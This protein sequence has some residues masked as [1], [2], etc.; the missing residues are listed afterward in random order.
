MTDT[1]RADVR[2]A[3]DSAL[4]RLQQVVDE[5]V[6]IDQQIAQQL[7]WARIVTSLTQRVALI[8]ETLPQLRQ[9]IAALDTETQEPQE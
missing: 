8:A 9:A 5:P 4:E 6:G 1:N 2:K 7:A 3:A